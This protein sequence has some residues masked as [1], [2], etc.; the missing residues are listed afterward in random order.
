MTLHHPSDLDAW[1]ASIAAARSPLRNLRNRLR[2]QPNPEPARLVLPRSGSL[3]APTS[4]QRESSAAD[5]AVDV[6]VL[7]VIDTPT[8]S[9]LAALIA[10]MRFLAPGRVAVLTTAASSQRLRLDPDA[11]SVT[12]SDHHELTRALPRLRCVLSYGHYMHLGAMADASARALGATSFISQHGIL[13]PF[14]PPLPEGSRLLA[15][16]ADD[17]DYWTHSRPD[18]ENHIVGSQL[19][20]EATPELTGD[21]NRPR[22]TEGITYLGQ[23]HG[24]ELPRR[25]MVAAAT[26]FCLENGATYRP[27]PSEADLASRLQHSIWRLRGIQFDLTRQPI[28]RLGTSVVSVFSTGVLEAAAAGIPAW[29]DHP[30]PPDWVEELWQRYRM[31][32]FGSLDPTTITAPSREPARVIAELID[33]HAGA[34]R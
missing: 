11:I 24:Y 20:H 3:T 1:Q 19:L 16:S 27:H 31:R 4:A 10:P 30:E 29:V 18:V 32:R 8:A 15:W 34:D 9:Q 22:P 14:A 13:T 28:D 2:S 25:S 7:I 21:E 6:D 23:L 5:V 17:A 26:R 12:I 33:E